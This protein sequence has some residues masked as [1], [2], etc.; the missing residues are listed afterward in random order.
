MVFNQEWDPVTGTYV[1][2]RDRTGPPKPVA[3]TGTTQE[4]DGNVVVANQA[5]TPSIPPP[6]PINVTLPGPSE[7]VMDANGRLNPRW[8]RFFNELYLRTGGLTDNINRAPQTF[9]VAG[10]ADALAFVGAAPTILHPEDIRVPPTAS[11]SITG[12]I[13]EPALSSPIEAPFVGSLSITGYAPTV[14][15]A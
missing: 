5:V 15:I 14:S 9:L 2:N 3:Y 4:S 6:T 8:W 10:A 7:P 11:I 1:T 13:A 12:N